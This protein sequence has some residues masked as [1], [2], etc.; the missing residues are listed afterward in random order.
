MDAREHRAAAVGKPLPNITHDRELYEAQLRLNG[1]LVNDIAACKAAYAAQAT[2]LDGM[3]DRDAAHA[4]Y[5]KGNND[6]LKAWGDRLEWLEGLV[7]DLLEKSEQATAI[8]RA[9]AERQQG[10]R[11]ERRAEILTRRM[12]PAAK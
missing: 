7:I 1:T 4:D 3:R 12:A 8:Q 2:E 9:M 6:L 11:M 10:L 5:A